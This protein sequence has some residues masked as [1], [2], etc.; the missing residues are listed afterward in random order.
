MAPQITTRRS[1]SNRSM[2]ARTTCVGRWSLSPINVLDERVLAA[3]FNFHNYGKT[4]IGARSDVERVPVENLAV[5][6]KKYY[7]P[8]DADLIVAGKFDESKALAMVAET[9]GSIPRPQ[10]VLTQPYT[11]E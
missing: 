4:V 8:D 9:I 3:A 11:V 6:Y 10:R 1:T 5:F 2:Q 7:Q